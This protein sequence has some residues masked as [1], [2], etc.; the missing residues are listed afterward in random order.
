MHGCLAWLLCPAA[1]WPCDGAHSVLPHVG[2]LGGLVLYHQSR[3]YTA[4][5]VAHSP[6][7]PPEP[8]CG[9]ARDHSV[10]GVNNNNYNYIIIIIKSHQRSTRF[11]SA[12]IY[13]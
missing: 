12:C 6:C 9:L 4:R 2:V 7:G 1:L 8:P 3:R 13:S 5:A 11:S 10:C